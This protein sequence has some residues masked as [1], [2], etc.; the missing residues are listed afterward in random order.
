M[1]KALLHNFPKVLM[2]SM[3]NIVE[4][5][6]LMCG[7]SKSAD[8]ILIEMHMPKSGPIISKLRSEILSGLILHDILCI[9]IYDVLHLLNLFGMDNCIKL[10]E[11]KSFEVYDNLGPG[12]G[13][14]ATGVNTYKLVSANITDSNFSKVTWLE[15][16]LNELSA[17]PQNNINAGQIKRVLTLLVSNTTVPNKGFVDQILFKETSHDIKNKNVT[18][19]F[20]ISSSDCE[21]I[22]KDDL[23]N[24]L[25][26]HYINR[27][28]IDAQR[29]DSDAIIIDEWAKVF[30]QGKL[31]PVMNEN[32]LYS[33]VETFKN[34]ILSNKGI[35]D[36]NGLFENRIIDIDDII[37]FRETSDGKLF[38]KW[39][40]GVNYDPDV[41][42]ATLL[43]RKPPSFRDKILKHLRFIYPAVIG[44][45]SNPFAGA[46]VRYLDSYVVQKIIEGWHPSLFLDNKFKFEIDKKIKFREKQ[47]KL[48]KLQKIHGKVGRN[49]P[50]PCESGR[51]FRKCCGR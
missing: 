26:L 39:I 36:L 46:G 47:D 14:L 13:A 22:K 32:G 1:N 17:K 9:D 25:R 2:P 11:S 16:R 7:G 3:L 10:L 33:S 5:D 30:L 34:I 51:K 35:P 24:I 38:R 4:D 27:G 37:G 40:S 8:L 19:I 15:E 41:I 50:C 44:L 31:S 6:G 43:N 18:E 23:P 21:A 49:D 28:L 20:N 42:L 12:T 45:F 29:I 48:E